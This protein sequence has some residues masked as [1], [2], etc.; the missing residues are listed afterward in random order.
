MDNVCPYAVDDDGRRENAQCVDSL[1]VFNKSF[2]ET[3][4][5]VNRCQL[6]VQ[7]V[8]RYVGSKY[9]HF[10][11]CAVVDGYRVGAHQRTTACIVKIRLRP[12]ATVGSQGPSIPVIFQIVVPLLGY[13]HGV[14]PS[15]SPKGVWLEAASLTGV[16][17]WFEAGKET[18]NLRVTL[19]LIAQGAEDVGWTLEPF[20]Q[21]I[22]AVDDGY[23]HTIEYFSHC[24]VFDIQQYLAVNP[25]I[26]GKDV[27][28]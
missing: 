24:L 3:V 20:L 18:Y 4:L 15:V 21:V 27:S 19:Q 17:V 6:S 7:P 8:Q 11:S 12:V 13:L 25:V 5:L 1:R 9:A 14:Y 10:A 28:F 26:V 22:S 23:L 2:E 16:V